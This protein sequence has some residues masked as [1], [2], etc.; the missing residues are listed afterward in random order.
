MRAQGKCP[1]QLSHRYTTPYWPRPSSL[2]SLG[3]P[4]RHKSLQSAAKS[5]FFPPAHSPGSAPGP[6]AKLEVPGWSLEF[7]VEIQPGSPLLPGEE[8]ESREGVPS[9]ILTVQQHILQGSALQGEPGQPRSVVLPHLQPQV[10]RPLQPARVAVLQLQGTP[11]T[12]RQHSGTLYTFNTHT[13]RLWGRFW[14]LGK[15][16]LKIKPRINAHISSP[17]GAA[18]PKGA[19]RCFSCPCHQ[20]PSFPARRK[21]SRAAP[22]GQSP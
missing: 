14:G 12:H 20:N 19:N 1:P 13:A 4:A 16:G 18:A 15:S 21:S 6:A 3:F 11:H 17:R 10:L 8:G 22:P 7:A 2:P 9:G 5:T